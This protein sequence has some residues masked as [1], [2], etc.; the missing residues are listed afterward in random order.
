MSCQREDS[1]QHIPVLQWAPVD[2]GVVH[3]HQ[4]LVQHETTHYGGDG[5]VRWWV[6][7]ELSLGEGESSG[8][9]TLAD[10]S[11][12]YR[13][14]IEPRAFSEEGYQPV[15]ALDGTPVWGY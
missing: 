7:T 11:F 9:I 13:R 3:L 12:S 14:V 4:L 6:V 15:T 8:E 5:S 2:N 1:Q 10:L